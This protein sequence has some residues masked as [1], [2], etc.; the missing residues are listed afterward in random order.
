MKWMYAHYIRSY[1]ESQPKD[2]GETMW[3]DLLENELGPLQ[4][5]SLEAVT[6]F[7]AVQGFRLGLKTG[8]ALAGDLETIPPTAGGA[9][10]QAAAFSGVPAQTM[11][12]PPSPAPIPAGR[13]GGPYH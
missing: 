4:R 8:M 2:D 6:A 10:S 9:H 5:E 7:F 1:I 11:V 12:P 13:D 3:F